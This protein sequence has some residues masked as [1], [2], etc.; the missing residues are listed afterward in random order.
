MYYMK[1]LKLYPPQKKTE[2]RTLP[3]VGRIMYIPQ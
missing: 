1:E 2:D 3:V